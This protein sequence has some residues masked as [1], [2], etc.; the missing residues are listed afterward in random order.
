MDSESRF[1]NRFQS[2]LPV[3]A[4]FVLLAVAVTAVT[5]VA[6]GGDVGALV[7]AL[8]VG[9]GFGVA[10]GGAYRLGRRYGQPHSHAVAQSAIIFGVA[11]LGAVVADLLRSSGRISDFL[12]GAGLA[13]SVVGT[14]LLLAVV[15]VVG[16]ATATG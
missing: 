14:L 15:A 7:W 11:V 13:G 2:G 16:R 9:S 8:G 5:V 3:V 1:E 10:V 4:V 12:I 6:L